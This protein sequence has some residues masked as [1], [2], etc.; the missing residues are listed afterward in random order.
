MAKGIR[1]EYDYNLENAKKDLTLE[2]DITFDGIS[3]S[4]YTQCADLYIPALADI[5]LHL[6]EKINPPAMRGRIE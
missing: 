1:Y 5:N 4:D 6:N 3:Y 2:G